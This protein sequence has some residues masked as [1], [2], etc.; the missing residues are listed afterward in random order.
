VSVPY[1]EWI[2]LNK[3]ARESGLE[4]AGVRCAY[5]EGLGVAAPGG[6]ASRE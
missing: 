5:V 2:E 3:K 4:L 6:G 1:F